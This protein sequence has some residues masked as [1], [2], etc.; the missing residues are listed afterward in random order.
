MV[1][2][3]RGQSKARRRVGG[4]SLGPL[5]SSAKSSECQSVGVGLGQWVSQSLG[6]SVAQWVGWSVGRSASR[7]LCQSVTLPVGHSASRSLCWSVSGSVGRWVS[8]SIRPVGRWVGGPARSVGWSVG[9]SL[10]WS[11]G[12]SASRWVGGLV[13]LLVGGLVGGPVG[14]SVGGSVGWPVCRMVGRSVTRT[15][16]LGDHST[17]QR[18]YVVCWMW[19]VGWSLVCQGISQAVSLGEGSICPSKL[20]ACSLLERQRTVC[21][22]VS[23]WTVLVSVCRSVGLGERRSVGMWSVGRS[24][25]GPVSQ[26]VWGSICQ[27]V[28]WHV[29]CWRGSMRSVGLSVGELVC[30][31][32]MCNL[33]EGRYAAHWDVGL[34]IC[35]ASVSQLVVQWIYVSVSMERRS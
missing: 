25:I 4:P 27:N 3:Q 19:L 2:L 29:V 22:R 24:V 35:R 13:A 26:P 31:E 6:Q 15:S 7:S 34:S 33:S 30:E 28:G 12:R 21:Q 5:V 1:S 14:Q 20:S 17:V 10:Y 18:L 8:Q 23:M 32:R 16:R 9:R 11:V